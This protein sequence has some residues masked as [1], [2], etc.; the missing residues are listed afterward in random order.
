MLYTIVRTVDV[1]NI[2][3]AL[4][5]REQNDSIKLETKFF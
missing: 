1:I 2:S 4:F 3:I 5:W